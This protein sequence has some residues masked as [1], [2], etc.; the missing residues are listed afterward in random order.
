MKKIL[1]RLQKAEYIII[2]AFF[3][4]MILASFLQVVNRNLLGWP[5]SWAEEVSRYCMVYMALLGTEIGLRDGSQLAITA[6][7]NNLKGVSRKM[8]NLIAKMVVV[9]YSFVVFATSFVLLDRQMRFGQLTPGLQIP[10]YLPY[11]ALTLSFGII[12]LAQGAAMIKMFA[13]FFRRMPEVEF[14]RKTG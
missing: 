6:I 4:I 1:A 11:F 12:F 8:L 13:D 10:M 5:I 2:V 14:C 9:A 7:V 3:I